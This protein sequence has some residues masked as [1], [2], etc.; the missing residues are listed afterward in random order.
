LHLLLLL[1]LPLPLR[2]YPC[3]RSCSSSCS[4]T[5]G[6]CAP[7]CASCCIPPVLRHSVEP[8]A[9]TVVPRTCPFLLHC[10]TLSRKGVKDC[11]LYEHSI[12]SF[13][14]SIL[15]LATPPV[16]TGDQ[17][18]RLARRGNHIAS[19]PTAETTTNPSPPLV[20]SSTSRHI[21][22]CLEGEGGPSGRSKL[23]SRLPFTYHRVGMCTEATSRVHSMVTILSSIPG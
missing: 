7:Y 17:V 12:L 2:P 21:G 8:G 22:P 4:G 1:L 23:P 14:Y 6:D 20:N 18:N 9:V 15:L 5:C 10:P 13:L 3:P 16:H 11:R 19:R